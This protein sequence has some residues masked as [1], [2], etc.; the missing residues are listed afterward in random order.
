MDKLIITILGIA[1]SAA[2]LLWTSDYISTLYNNAASNTRAQK[3][4][5][6][7]AQVA[8][9]ARQAGALSLTGDNW[10]QG[11]SAS[12]VAGALVTSYMVDLPKHNGVYIFLPCKITSG[13]TSCPVYVTDTTHATD[14]TML[15][16]TVENLA[17]CK[18]INQISN[19]NST[20]APPT[21]TVSGT[22]PFTISYTL[23]INSNQQFACVNAS[24]TYYFL[25][26]V[27]LDR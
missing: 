9:A 2:T 23:P 12:L 1:L 17:V 15:E 25:Y 3:W 24:G 14:A 11:A 27:F 6:D 20:A 7:A 22:N 8:V 4:I 13:A 10:E 19:R 5:A 26:R 16:A 21:A 18:A